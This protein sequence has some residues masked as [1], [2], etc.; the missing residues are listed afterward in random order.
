MLH[1]EKLSDG[2][3]EIR[4]TGKL[5]ESDFRSLAIQIDGWIKSSGHL[6][7]LVNATAFEGWADT[8]AASEHFRFVRDHHEKVDRI[9]LLAGHEWQ[10]WI[11]SFA[12]HFV[13]P[14]LRV[15]KATE[16]TQAMAWLQEPLRKA[17]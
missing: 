11:A 17:S 15:F 8:H 1:I 16:R 10:H 12:A 7:L 9:A 6:R 13:H 14:E 2:V 3:L 5:Q 4:P